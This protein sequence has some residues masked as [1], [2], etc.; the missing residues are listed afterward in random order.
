MPFTR[1]QF[2]QMFADYNLAIWP[3]QI[4]AYALAGLAIAAVIFRI[5]HA[6]RIATLVL[7][8]FWFWNGA[9]YHAAFFSTINPAAF[10]FAALFLAQAVIFVHSGI[11]GRGLTLSVAPDLRTGVAMILIVYALAGYSLLGAIRGHVWPQAP[12]FGVAPCP[13]AI[14]TFGLLMLARDRSRPIVFLIPVVWA[15]VGTSAAILMSVTEDWGLAVAA[16]AYLLMRFH[17]ARV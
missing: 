16:A 15:A 6:S 1:E 3:A 8:V 9:A 17:P 10:A 2:F 11:S 12:V 4:V 7:A 14:F 5:P 13:T